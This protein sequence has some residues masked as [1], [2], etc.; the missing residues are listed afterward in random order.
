MMNIE[1]YDLIGKQNIDKN[2]Y[3]SSFTE[4]LDEKIERITNFKYNK[5]KIYKIMHPVKTIKNNL[6]YNK[7]TVI[8][9]EIQE[10]YDSNIMLFVDEETGNLEEDLE[11][12]SR[13]VK[14]KYMENFVKRLKLKK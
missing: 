7:L 6:E 2:K 1:K 4:N 3:I 9:N 13:V 12:A 8:K 14:P 11:Y 5:S 10:V